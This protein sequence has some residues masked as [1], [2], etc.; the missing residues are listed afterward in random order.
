[1]F[2]MKRILTVIISAAMVLSLAACSA[3]ESSAP[4]QETKVQS[5]EISSSAAETKS[6]ASK[7]DS[8]DEKKILTVYFSADNNNTDT[9]TGA[10][11][12]IDNS[13]VTKYIAQQINSSVGGETAP[14]IPEEDYPTGY[15]AVADQAKSERDEGARPKFTVSVNPEEYDVIFVGY[16]VWWYELPM[17]MD[18][19]FETYDFSGKTIIPFNTHE[20]SRDGGT[21]DQIREFEPNAE[22]INGFNITGSTDSGEIDSSVKEWLDGLEY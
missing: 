12:T 2:Q 3:A 21:Y 7:T 4:A 9:V 22:V 13:A 5:S 11:P 19:F 17:V 1:M 10:T 20:G 15:D 18:T 8:T 16:P 6:D 14:I